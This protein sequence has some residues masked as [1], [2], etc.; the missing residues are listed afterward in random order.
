MPEPWLEIRLG[1]I[2]PGKVC[3]VRL[4]EEAPG[5]RWSDDP[6]ELPGIGSLGMD[7]QWGESGP[8]V[9]L[10]IHKAYVRIVD[11]DDIATGDV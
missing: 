4:L 10:R 7:H 1:S 5:V 6:M 11:D 2:G 8:W 3:K 9:T